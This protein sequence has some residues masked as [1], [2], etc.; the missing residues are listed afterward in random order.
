MSNPHVG[1]GIILRNDKGEILVGKRKGSHA[2]FFSI[3][4][5][6]LEEGES[7]E[8][9]A[10]REML[11]ETSVVIKSPKV[12]GLSNNIKT[13]QEEGVH[14]ISVG[15]FADEYS[16]DIKLMEPEK[17]EGWLWVDPIELPQPHFDASTQL[18][19]CFLSGEFYFAHQT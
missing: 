8:E 4:G 11:E 1:V 9:A 10:M 3:P 17:C 6:S 19:R 12:I 5:G 16:G 14:S 13:Y 7:F 15:L 2:P 18:I